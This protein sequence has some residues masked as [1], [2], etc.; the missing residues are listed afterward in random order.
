MLGFERMWRSILKKNKQL[1][2]IG[3]E[4]KQSK[5]TFTYRYLLFN[6][7]SLFLLLS[8]LIL[9]L[10]LQYYLFMRVSDVVCVYVYV[11]T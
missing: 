3:T 9:L 1:R 11:C 10:L 4:M 2:N 5:Y 8:L 6:Y 7:Q